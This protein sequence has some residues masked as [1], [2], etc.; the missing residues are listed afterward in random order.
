MIDFGPE[1]G[2]ILSPS[3]G[4]GELV[5]SAE[6]SSPHKPSGIASAN[7]NPKHLG[8][9]PSTRLSTVGSK[10][11]VTPRPIRAETNGLVVSKVNR[12][13]SALKTPV[14]SLTNRWPGSARVVDP[15][16]HAASGSTSITQ[17]LR[18]VWLATGARIRPLEVML[19]GSVSPA[20][21]SWL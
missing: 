8:F 13:L 21:E 1:Y 9:R 17:I 20:L 7:A 16:P 19:M 2:G 14:A 5:S 3:E 11:S 15:S 18:R 10:H 4:V 6:A 12:Q